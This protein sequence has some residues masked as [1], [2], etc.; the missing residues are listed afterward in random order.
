MMESDNDRG[1]AGPASPKKTT[2]PGNPGRLGL[3]CLGWK[4]NDLKNEIGTG[5]AS[6]LESIRII[7]FAGKPLVGGK[8]KIRFA[9][10]RLMPKRRPSGQ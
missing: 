2:Y 5:L 1:K 7:Y 6:T 10:A 8:I 9:T 4:R 3:G